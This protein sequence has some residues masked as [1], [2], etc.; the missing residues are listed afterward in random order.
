MAYFKP[1]RGRKYFI[2]VTRAIPIPIATAIATPILCTNTC[3][4]Q[5]D[6]VC[7]MD[8]RIDGQTQI[9]A[10]LKSTINADTN[11]QLLT[12]IQL[13]FYNILILKK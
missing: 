1:Q 2:S 11:I 6:E 9:D 4:N 8:R 10:I 12:N 3:H 13:P 5:I 7:W